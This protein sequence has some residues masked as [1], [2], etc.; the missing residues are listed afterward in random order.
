MVKFSLNFSIEGF[1]K[2]LSS[3]ADLSGAQVSP[4]NIEFCIAEGDMQVMENTPA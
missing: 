1:D 3:D 4:K 2:Q